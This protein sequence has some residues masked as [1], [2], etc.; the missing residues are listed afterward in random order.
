MDCCN[1][2]IRPVG[3]VSF[4]CLALW[5]W[6]DFHTQPPLYGREGLATGFRWVE[7]N[8]IWI[9]GLKATAKYMN[10]FMQSEMWI[11]RGMRGSMGQWNLTLWNSAV[12]SH[13]SELF[14]KER[15]R[16][17]LPIKLSRIEWTVFWEQDIQVDCTSNRIL[18]ISLHSRGVTGLCLHFR[19]YLA[20][21]FE[22]QTSLASSPLLLAI[23][24]CR[25]GVIADENALVSNHSFHVM[26]RMAFG[27]YRN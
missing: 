4:V 25:V 19:C 14:G 21:A 18:D 27:L 9:I 2:G 8:I 24:P 3:G 13:E 22:W 20:N 1:T 5:K 6:C 17:H 23:A 15:R 12:W 26:S 11:N 10:I 7:N 16:L